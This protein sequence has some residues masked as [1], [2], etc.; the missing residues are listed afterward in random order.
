MG[1]VVLAPRRL[2]DAGPMQGGPGRT[3]PGEMGPVEA[4]GHEKG[5][6]HALCRVQALLRQIAREDISK[7][8][9]GLVFLWVRG[10]ASF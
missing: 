3:A 1:D 10:G 6:L 2:R 9:F 4:H 7:A 8:M 5:A